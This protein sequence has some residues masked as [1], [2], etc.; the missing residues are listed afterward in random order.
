[1]LMALLQMQYN[2][3]WMGKLIGII[4]PKLIAFLQHN[5]LHGR[6][7]NFRWQADEQVSWWSRP[8]AIQLENKTRGPCQTH[9]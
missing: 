9:S 8:T 7:I 5:D 6:N 1:M 2:Y 4:Y 3:I